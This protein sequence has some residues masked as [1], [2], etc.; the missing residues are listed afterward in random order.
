MRNYDVT[1]K[2]LLQRALSGSVLGEW[3]G[4]RVARWHNT[5]LPVASL[6]RVDLLGEDEQGNLIHIE[7]QSRNDPGMALRMA[8]Y[9]LSIYRAQGR[10]PRQVVLYVGP[11]RLGMDCELAAEDV[12]FRCR[13][14]DI[15]ELNA[16][17]LLASERIED[18]VLAI[19]AGGLDQRDV[20]VRILRKIAEGPVLERTRAL[21]ELVVLAGLRVTASAIIEEEARQMPIVI[22]LMQHEYFGPKLRKAWE[23]GRVEGRVEGQ[24]ETEREMLLRLLSRRFDSVPDW[25]RTR[26]GGMTGPEIEQVFDRAVTAPSLEDLFR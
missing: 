16:E 10:F 12:S 18:N 11:E 17:V 20:A 21:G 3:V 8:E 13:I 24:V 25:V 9:A 4:V 15:R 22:D 6:R 2:G 23:D 1:L 7:L 5:E 19:L 26:L 14:A